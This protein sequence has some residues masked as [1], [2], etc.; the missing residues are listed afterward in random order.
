M[1]FVVY[2]DNEKLVEETTK[3]LGNMDGIR[4]MALKLLLSLV[5][6]GAVTVEFLEVEV[7]SER[8]GS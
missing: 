8:K 4:T 6:N 5:E 7:K 2:I 1:K 3:L